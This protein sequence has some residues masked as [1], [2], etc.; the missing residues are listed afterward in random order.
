M[1]VAGPKYRAVVFD[2]FGTLVDNPP[3]DTYQ[4]ALLQDAAR[5]GVPLSDFQRLW[6]ETS[7]ERHTG[8]IPTIEANLGLICRRLG[9]TVTASRVAEAA[10]ARYDFIAAAVAPR[11][12]AASTLSAIRDRGMKVALVSNCSPETPRIWEGLP[13]KPF[14]DATFFSSSAGVTKP[15]RR[16]Y[17][18]ALRSLTLNG[19]DCLYVGDGE[20]DELTGAAAVGMDPV[21]IRAPYEE[22]DQRHV[23]ARQQWDGPVISS[24]AEVL[25]LL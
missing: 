9:V 18:M 4:E 20:S 16:I 17:E 1:S 3:Y 11:S 8:A 6:A 10:Q 13:L 12:D 5:L 23:I 15:D 19:T 24:L 21:M 25:T 22:A 7:R 2:L 14:F